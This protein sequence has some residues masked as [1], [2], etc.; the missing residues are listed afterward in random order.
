MS[1]SWSNSIGFGD[2]HAIAEALRTVNRV[3][4]T[5]LP[6]GTKQ[7]QTGFSRPFLLV[8]GLFLSLLFVLLLS[9]MS[10]AREEQT[11]A[12]PSFASV[13]SLLLDQ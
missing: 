11:A 2:S 12:Q 13:G 6:A 7:S 3:P 5:R 8:V 9:G 1:N 10:N 4:P